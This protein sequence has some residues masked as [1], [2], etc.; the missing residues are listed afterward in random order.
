MPNTN[1]MKQ[2]EFTDEDFGLTGLRITLWMIRAVL[3]AI[4]IVS[5][6]SY[7]ETQDFFAGNDVDYL[8]FGGIG[9]ISHAMAITFQFG[10]SPLFWLFLR[11]LKKAGLKWAALTNLTQT[12]SNVRQVQNYRY[13][14]I[15]YGISAFVFLFAWGLFCFVDAGSNV[16]EVQKNVYETEWSYIVMMIVAVGC[17]FIEELFMFILDIHNHL[18]AKVME[19]AALE[20][21]KVG[22][23]ASY[24]AGIADTFKSWQKPK[25]QTTYQSVTS[26]PPY[27]EEEDF[28]IPEDPP[29]TYRPMSP[30]PKKVEPVYTPLKQDD[31]FS[32]L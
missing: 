28:I 9:L 8:T 12:R 20:G 1:R 31:M 27:D 21:P 3:V 10:Q 2:Y 23:G 14:T 32:D 26:R 5:V 7:N 24:A 29:H 19:L 6:W 18:R 30:A 15:R 11:F 17:V 13:D 22:K 4:V 25:T 16:I